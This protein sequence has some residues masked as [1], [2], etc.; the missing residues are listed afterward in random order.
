MLRRH[1]DRL[2][3]VE[4]LHGLGEPETG[5]AEVLKNAEG[6]DKT[7]SVVYFGEGDQVLV[8]TPAE[9]MLDDETERWR[10]V[11]SVKRDLVSAPMLAL[12]GGKRVKPVDVAA[13]CCAS[14]GETPRSCTST[15][16]C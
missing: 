10:V 14:C 11:T 5:Q 15:S 9:R 6:E 12:P 3:D 16:R 13:E 1:R 4:E 8:G 2:W 7:P